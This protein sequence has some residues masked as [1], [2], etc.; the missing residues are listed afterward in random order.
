MSK[1]EKVW[2]EQYKDDWGRLWEV[3]KAQSQPV[4][5]RKAVEWESET[6]YVIVDADGWRNEGIPYDQPI[7]EETFWRLF[8][9]STILGGPFNG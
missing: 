5:L 8:N 9:Q 1:W 7:S 6:D 2:T 4:R 3:E